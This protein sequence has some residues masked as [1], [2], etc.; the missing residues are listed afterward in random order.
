MSTSCSPHCFQ[1]LKLQDNQQES[2]TLHRDIAASMMKLGINDQQLNRA[3][4]AENLPL[5]D[6]PQGSDEYLGDSRLLGET[7]YLLSEI[8]FIFN[9]YKEL[10]LLSFVSESHFWWRPSSKLFTNR[11]KTVFMQSCKEI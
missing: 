8:I 6:V 1:G 2:L 3:N 9:K 10:S 7:F 11:T 4:I 5:F